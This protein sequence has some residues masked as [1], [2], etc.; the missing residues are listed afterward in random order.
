MKDKK[1]CNVRGHCYYTG[2]YRGT[3]HS[4]CYSKYSLPEKI[5]IVFHNESNYD[6][7]FTIKE[8]A[9]ELRKQFTCFG[10]NTEKYITF[11][12][13]REKEVTRIDKN[14]EKN[15]KTFILHITNYW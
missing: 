7:L 14:G 1:Y 8:L 15:L 9:G 13:P 12:V 4:I 10:E 11:T 6:Y 3:A 2:E 5:P